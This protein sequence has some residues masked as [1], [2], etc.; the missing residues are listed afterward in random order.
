MYNGQIIP[1]AYRIIRTTTLSN[2]VNKGRAKPNC[3]SAGFCT[4]CT[5]LCAVYNLAKKKR[6]KKP[7]RLPDIR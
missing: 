3:Y 4:L 5:V 2:P 6:A 1:V 7:F